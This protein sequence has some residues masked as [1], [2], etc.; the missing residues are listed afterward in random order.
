MHDQ[1]E[2]F[3]FIHDSGELVIATT[4]SD[5]TGTIETISREYFKIHLTQ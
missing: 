4:A 5:F 2:A 3:L 1:F